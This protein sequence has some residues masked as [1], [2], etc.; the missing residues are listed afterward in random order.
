MTST[1]PKKT[2]CAT[3]RHWES[4]PERTGIRAGIEGGVGECHQRPPIV[5]Y[6]FTRTAATD[7]C[8]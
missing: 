7:W 8:G 3:C 5:N 4:L 6:T 2:M 1:E